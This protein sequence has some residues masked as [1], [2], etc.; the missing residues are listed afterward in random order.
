METTP[1]NMIGIL[2]GGGDVPGLNPC[3]KQL[4]VNAHQFGMTVLGIGQRYGTLPI[5]F[6]AGAIHDC[7]EHLDAD[8]GSGAGFL[9]RYF[10]AGG[11]L[12]A[13]DQAMAFYRRPPAFRASQVHR[14]MTDSLT[15]FGPENVVRQTIDL[16]THT[17]GRQLAP[18]KTASDLPASSR[19]AA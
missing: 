3:I 10:D 19:I 4:V 8:A 9:F 6:D 15:R 2:T 11:F 17:L 18:L 12:W 5:A 1:G 13:M 16:Y 14:I 7:V